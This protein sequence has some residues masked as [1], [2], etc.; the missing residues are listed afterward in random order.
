MLNII[1]N[2][3]TEQVLQTRSGYWASSVVCRNHYL[4]FSEISNPGYVAMLETSYGH[5]FNNCRN[6]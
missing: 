6:M 5:L 1:K 3:K 2:V 4:D